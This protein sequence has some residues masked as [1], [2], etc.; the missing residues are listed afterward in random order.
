[1]TGALSLCTLH[2][3]CISALLRIFAVH[4]ISL[5]TLTLHHARTILNSHSEPGRTIQASGREERWVIKEALCRHDSHCACVGH[6]VVH[7]LQVP[8]IAVCQHRDADSLPDCLQAGLDQLLEACLSSAHANRYWARHGTV[9]EQTCNEL[10][11]WILRLQHQR[12]HADRSPCTCQSM[13]LPGLARQ[14]PPS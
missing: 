7:V 13:I 2:S 1:M 5:I 14:A 9:A 12:R 8:H 10:C 3:R 4:C 6:A 11:C